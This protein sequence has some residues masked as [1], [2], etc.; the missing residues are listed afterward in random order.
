VGSS[1]DFIG[2]LVT[3]GGGLQFLL[4]PLPEIGGN[5]R[6]VIAQQQIDSVAS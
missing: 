5:L 4:N 1:P 3:K 2:L 6:V